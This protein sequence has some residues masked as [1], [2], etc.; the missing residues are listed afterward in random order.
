[1]NDLKTEHTILKRGT[2]DEEEKWRKS[3]KLGS[4]IGDKEELARRKQLSAN[5]LNT[6]RPIWS[7]EPT[8]S[9]NRR[10]RIYNAYV[11]PVLTY[12]MATLALSQNQED[13]LDAFHR[14]QLRTII[15]IHDPNH[16]SNNDLYQRTASKPISREMFRA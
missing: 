7:R 2:P 1:M 4:L 3:K 15:G 13:E 14:R 9:I 12:N 11:L 6:C 5:A 16:I 10:V 8:I